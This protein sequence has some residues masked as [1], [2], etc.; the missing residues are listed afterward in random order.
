M[1][2]LLEKEN[3]KCATTIPILAGAMANLATTVSAILLNSP[4]LMQLAWPLA[5]SSLSSSALSFPAAPL[6]AASSAAS[7]VSA[8]VPKRE[9]RLLLPKTEHLALG[10]RPLHHQ[11]HDEKLE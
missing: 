7:W 6:S 11:S 10:G 3:Q 8:S 2:N 4:A 5:S 9:P 1:G